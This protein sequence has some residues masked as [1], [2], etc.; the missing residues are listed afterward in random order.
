MG[1]MTS[2]RPALVPM[3]AGQ[4]LRAG[5]TGRRLPQ[6]FLGLLL[7]GVSMGMM[8][9]STLGLNPWDVLHYGITLYVPLSIGQVTIV[10]GLLVLLAWWPLRVS[11]G[12]GT[13]ANVLLIGLAV[14]ATLLVLPEPEHLVW[15]SLLL[16]GGIISNGLAIALYLG[17]QYGPGPRDGL[18]TGLA[19]R[20][21]RSLRLVRTVLEITV[22][23][24][25][26][27][28]GGIVGVG[29]VLYAL[30]IGPLTQLFLPHVT[31]QLEPPG[32]KP[33]R[34]PQGAAS[35]SGR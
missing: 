18:M 28:L 11:P 1:P 30:L 21:G 35:D 27:L 26:W 24:I 10:L 3:T 4:Q 29:T 20:T 6:L 34:R 19:L 25:G 8:I 17:A 14:D 32:P 31:V 7:F 33:L 16:L 5:R 9:R 13:V 2:T 15:R 12:L 23:G 22:L